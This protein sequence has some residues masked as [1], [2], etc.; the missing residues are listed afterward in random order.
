MTKNRCIKF[1]W[2][3]LNIS[4]II[5]LIIILKKNEA[6]GRVD[7]SSTLMNNKANISQPVMDLLASHEEICS[8]VLG[9]SVKC[10]ISLN[11]RT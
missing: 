9:L 1:W 6:K 5:T 10:Y 8:M 4:G 3:D 7:S 11:L 2:R